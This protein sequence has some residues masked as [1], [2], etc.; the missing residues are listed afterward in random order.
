MKKLMRAAIPA[1]LL[2]G[3]VASAQNY[4]SGIGV[5][6]DAGKRGTMFGIQYKYFFGEYIAGEF[7]AATEI[8]N[9]LVQANFHFQ[10][11]LFN[12]RNLD[13]YVGT[14]PGLMYGKNLNTSEKSFYFAPAAMVGLDLSLG[15]LPLSVAADWRPRVFV[16]PDSSVELGRFAAG[17]KY[18]FY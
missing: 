16:G 9:S 5:I 1:F 10:Y 18:T 13:F 4:T 6:A 7:S 2:I 12:S 11:P 15:D 3:S 17:I 14:G 8:E